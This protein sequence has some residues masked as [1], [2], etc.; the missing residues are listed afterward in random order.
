M[1][2]IKI[3]ELTQRKTCIVKIIRLTPV[4]VVSA[5]V[6]EGKKGRGGGRMGFEGS[7]K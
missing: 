5:Q 1:F 4:V 7:I 3:S 6:E 2:V